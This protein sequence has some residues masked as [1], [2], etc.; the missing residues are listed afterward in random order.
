MRWALVRCGVWA[1]L[2]VGLVVGLPYSEKIF[3]GWFPE[4]RT[5]LYTRQSF[6]GLLWAH[7]SLVGLSSLIT[8]GVGV[9]ACIAVTRGWGRTF[10]PLL[11][12]LVSLGQSIPPAVVLA[13]SV[14]M[15][16]FGFMPALLALVLYG[17]L[18]IVENA[19]KAFAQL[20]REA[21]LAARGLGFSAW[22]RLLEVELP[23]A[24]PLIL[25]GVRTSVMINVATATIASTVGTQS[26][27]SPIIAGLTN[28]NLPF[29]L[30]GVALVVV[31]ALW[32][33]AVFEVV[34]AW[35]ARR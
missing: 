33:D 9:G 27:G 3:A 31:L 34:L 6:A 17:L 21:L 5:P 22:Q 11:S 26:L 12:S 28:Y 16:G 24:F 29:V 23:L 2:L 25:A 8:V 35:S 4:V 7:L 1:V 14:P 13:L 18:P 20:P 10:A 30:Q 15:V 32:L 19:L